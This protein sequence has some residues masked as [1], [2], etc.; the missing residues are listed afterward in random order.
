MIDERE[1]GP[2]GHGDSGQGGG[3]LSSTPCRDALERQLLT[4]A[5]VFGLCEGTWAGHGGLS[6][7]R[8]HPKT[9]C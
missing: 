9:L 8:G 3:R 7:H 4:E 1:L 5:G 2:M 6:G